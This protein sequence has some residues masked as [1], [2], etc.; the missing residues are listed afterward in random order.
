ME[1]SESGLACSSP[2]ALINLINNNLVGVVAQIWQGEDDE[3]C[4]LKGDLRIYFFEKIF[5]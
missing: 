1:R 3:V 2:T 4:K 5:G